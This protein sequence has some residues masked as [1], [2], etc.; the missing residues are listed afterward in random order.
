MTRTTWAIALGILI[1]VAAS[2]LLLRPSCTIRNA[3]GK[4]YLTPDSKWSVTV[5]E[6]TCSSRLSSDARSYWAVALR[7]ASEA[8]Q[9]ADTYGDSEIVFEVAKGIPP[10]QVGITAPSVI[11][12]FSYL[13]D[14]EKQH[15]LLLMCYPNC[16]RE[17][18][19]RQ[20]RVWH[21]VPVHYFVQ[22]RPNAPPS[23]E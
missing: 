17:S 7:P 21:G 10:V 1:A 4:S 22:E 18:I 3:T 13:S 9:S 20:S 15:S 19:R 16:P 23:I 5:F 6:K 8:A 2:A 12:Q 14:S 11:P